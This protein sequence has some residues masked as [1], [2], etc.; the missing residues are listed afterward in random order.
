[1][2]VSWKDYGACVG[3]P[4]D[5]FYPPD[6]KAGLK[7]EAKAKAICERCTVKQACLMAALSNG[8]FGIWGATN[9][10]E[11]KSMKRRLRKVKASEAAG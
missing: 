3:S 2:T 11:R 9:E 5:L 4:T 10:A 7:L 8:E 6:S 1:M